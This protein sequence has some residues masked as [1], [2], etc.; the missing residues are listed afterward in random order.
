M[1]IGSFKNFVLKSNYGVS[2][3]VKTTSQT[4]ILETK[5]QN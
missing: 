1:N 4:L 3:S 2:E 5:F